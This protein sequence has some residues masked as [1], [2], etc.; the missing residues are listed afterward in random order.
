MPSHAGGCAAG[1]PRGWGPGEQAWEL[2]SEKGQVKWVVIFLLLFSFLIPD[3][4]MPLSSPKKEKELLML[5]ILSSLVLPAILP[6]YL[7]VYKQS[8]V[9]L[10]SFLWQVFLGTSYVQLHTSVFTLWG[11]CYLHTYTLHLTVITV[12]QKYMYITD[13]YASLVCLLLDSR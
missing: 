12:L 7:A 10:L 13:S 3:G 5:L 2:I 11:S 8:S 1:G 9:L 4:F 6:V